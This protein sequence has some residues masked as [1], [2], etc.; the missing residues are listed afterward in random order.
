MSKQF[1]EKTDKKDAKWIADLLKHDLI[2][3]SFIPSLL[4]R[5]LRDL[6]RYPFKL[7]NFCSSEANR[8]Q[9]S[10]TISNITLCFLVF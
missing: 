7:T 8:L 3:E 2:A 9:N 4:I 5:E 6:V 10:L 1:V